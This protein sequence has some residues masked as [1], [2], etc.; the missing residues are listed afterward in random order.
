MY[1]Y[2][3]YLFIKPAPLFWTNNTCCNLH[4][5]FICRGCSDQH[6][7]ASHCIPITILNNTPIQSKLYSYN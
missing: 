7:G 5:S 1:V 2:F 6:H 4:V 3:I